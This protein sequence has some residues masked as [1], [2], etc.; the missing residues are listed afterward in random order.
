MLAG[1][2]TSRI[3]EA[4]L[5][6]PLCTA[7]QVVLVDLLRAAGIK[8]AAVVGHSSVEIG[9]AYAAGFLTAKD[10]IQVAYYR[11]STL[12]WLAMLAMVRRAPCWL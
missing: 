5:F 6:Q 8:F 11:D 3:A 12:A 1:A 9:A 10:A 2:D 4:A 7:I